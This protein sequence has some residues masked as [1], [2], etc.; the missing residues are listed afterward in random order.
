MGYDYEDYQ[1]KIDEIIRTIE[2]ELS[3]RGWFLDGG[4]WTANVVID[5]VEKYI[6]PRILDQLM[7]EGNPVYGQGADA[8]A[9]F[10]KESYVS[11]EFEENL[12]EL[13]VSEEA[14]DFLDEDE[15]AW[16]EVS[17]FI[18]GQISP[19]IDIGALERS[20]RDLGY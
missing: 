1:E 4:E 3:E 18:Q 11:T 19:S 13:G 8:V 7:N 10:I 12:E 17:S 6:S 16:D 5:D 14:L 9:E 2:N 20:L 15:D